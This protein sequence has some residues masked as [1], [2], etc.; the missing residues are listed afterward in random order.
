MKDIITTSNAAITSDT[1]MN[2]AMAKLRALAASETADISQILPYRISVKDH[3][4][5]AVYMLHADGKGFFAKGDVHAIKAKQKGGKTNA[6]AMM[7]AAVL[8]G[9]NGLLTCSVPDSKVLVIDTEQNGRDTQRIYKMTLALAGLPEEDIYDRFQTFCLRSM[10]IAQKH[11]ALQQLIAHFQ[12][13][14]VFV[15][16]IVD[17]VNSFNDEAESKNFITEL[18]RL[19]TKEIS[20]KETAIVCVLHTNKSKEDDNMRGHLGT[21]LAQKSS[22]NLMV[23]RRGY[24]F[25]VS[26]ACSR[27]E[28][29]PSWSFTFRD[30]G[31][32]TM[33]ECKRKYAISEDNQICG[34][35][36]RPNH[37]TEVIANL[38]Q[39]FIKNQKEKVSSKEL[40]YFLQGALGMSESVVKK[41]ITEMTSIGYIAISS[42]YYVTVP[43]SSRR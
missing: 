39:Q 40:K 37:T 4:P 18:M 27:H 5:E 19:S 12:P 33:C 32:L 13:D 25:T 34:D 15:D 6:I 43:K 20:G 31:M 29:L 2:D 35:S 1:I 41:K 10:D 21:I 42:D 3:Y 11:S 23:E 36:S 26:D 28:L 16:G 7:A 38:T 8:S 30:D 22:T 9:K 24:T 14:I 17:M